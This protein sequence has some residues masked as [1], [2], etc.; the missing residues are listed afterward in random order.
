MDG[1][2]ATKPAAPQK[3]PLTGLYQQDYLF[4]RAAALLRRQKSHKVIASLA[5]LQ[6]ENFYEIRRWV[7]KSE[8]DLLLSDIA[9]LLRQSLPSPVL[10]CRCA[11][12]E[13][14]AL[15]TGEFSIHAAVHIQ[16]VKQALHDATSESI[17]PQLDLKCAV[18]TASVT[19]SVPSAEVLFAR[20][21]HQLSMQMSRHRHTGAAEIT[22]SRAR[23]L[24]AART[25]TQ[26]QLLSI[27]TSNGLELN[28]QALIN[29]NCDDIRRYEVR[30]NTPE[31]PE[32]AGPLLAAAVNNALGDR[33]DRW[34]IGRSLKLLQLDRQGDM[35]LI[36]NLTQNSLVSH[37]FFQWLRAQSSAYANLYKKLVFQISEL[38]LLSAQHHMNYC[39]RVL[40]ELGIRLC[41]SQFGCT[42]DPFRYLSLMQ[43]HYVKLHWALF[44]NAHKDHHQ[45]S[46][47]MSVVAR[48]QQMG[49]RAIA[50][51][52]E[53]MTLL[54]TLWSSNVNLV[55]GYALH[56]PAAKPDY[57]FHQKQT[58]DYADM[59]TLSRTN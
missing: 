48:L 20:A 52:V 53:E 6:L 5:L 24:D 58:L 18:G 14:A 1:S 26:S 39:S 7:G 54:P 37:A 11:H 13:F 33:I 59:R 47:L 2:I 12:Y 25:L 35:R 17:P 44:A 34:V 10:L 30:C 27:L 49:V 42:T 28:F 40:H 4:L 3:D 21:R 29:L 23:W 19:T 31:N 46:Q 51:E 32:S 22:D 43:T 15:F 9:H 8:A 16:R 50:G 45:R 41:V 57:R 36:V 38:D 55:Q 56:E